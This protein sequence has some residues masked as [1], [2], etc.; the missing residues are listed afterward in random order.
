MRRLTLVSSWLLIAGV[1]GCG[2]S[3][4]PTEPP[5]SVAAQWTRVS[6]GL[7]SNT[8]VTSFAASGTTLLAGANEGVF[9]STDGGVTWTAATTQPANSDVRSLAASGTTLLAGTNGGGVFRSTAGGLTWVALGSGP[10]ASARV[11]SLTVSG[12]TLF[13]GTLS[14]AGVMRYPL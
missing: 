5:A 11:P 4:S 3:S 1:M 7:P 9:R 13:A 6:T 2:K 12:T 10:I 8:I 14:G